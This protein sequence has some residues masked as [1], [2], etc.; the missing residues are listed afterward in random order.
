MRWCLIDLP[1]EWPKDHGKGQLTTDSGLRVAKSNFLARLRIWILGFG[2]NIYDICYIVFNLH[3]KKLN[4]CGESDQFGLKS[5][6]EKYIFA[7]LR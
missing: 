5:E 4:F 1:K 2:D 6:E 7:S 3:N